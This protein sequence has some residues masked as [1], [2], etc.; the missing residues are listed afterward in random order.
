MLPGE[1][2]LETS[3]LWLGDY[4]SLEDDVRVQDLAVRMAEGID[5]RIKSGDLQASFE[6]IVSGTGGLVART[7]RTTRHRG[8]AGRSP[9]QRL[10]MLAPANMR[11]EKGGFTGRGRRGADLHRPPY[12]LDQLPATRPHFAYPAQA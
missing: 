8:D 7:W 12:A 3:T 9:V 4:I 10:V 6:V 1:E 2:R 11:R 5:Q